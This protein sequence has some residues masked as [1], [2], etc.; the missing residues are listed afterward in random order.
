VTVLATPSNDGQQWANDAK[1]NFHIILS[2]LLH[3]MDFNAYSCAFPQMFNGYILNCSVMVESFAK[4]HPKCLV[5]DLIIIREVAKAGIGLYEGE[6]IYRS[7][8]KVK[9]L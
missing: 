5:F 3:L 4:S 9:Q 7:Q 8:M 6:S 2:N 1:A